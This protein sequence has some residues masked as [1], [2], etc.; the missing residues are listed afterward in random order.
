MMKRLVNIFSLPTL[1]ALLILVC[2]CAKPPTQAPERTV[3]APAT[4]TDERGFD[5]LELPRDREIVPLKRPRSGSIKA[6]AWFSSS[7]QSSSGP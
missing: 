1:S 3:D 7:W 2:G 6:L 4:V 5:P